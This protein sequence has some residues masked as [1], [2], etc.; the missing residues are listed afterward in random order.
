MIDKLV[1]RDIFYR[2]GLTNTTPFTYRDGVTYLDILEEIKWKILNEIKPSIENMDEEVR[3]KFAI[4]QANFEE[5]DKQWTQ[6]LNS[7]DPTAVRAYVEG[8]GIPGIRDDFNAFRTSLN[9][10][11]DDRFNNINGSLQSVNQLIEALNTLTATHTSQIATHTSQIDSINSNFNNHHTRHEFGG[12]DELTINIK[13]VKDLTRSN[14]LNRLSSGYF[15]CVFL[16][17]SHTNDG[18]LEGPNGWGG[19]FGY[20]YRVGNL[21]AQTV[22]ECQEGINVSNPTGWGNYV[23]EAATGGMTSGTYCPSGTVSNIGVLKPD[24][25]FHMIGTNDYANLISPSTYKTNVRKAINDI[26]NVSSNTIQILIVP[27]PRASVASTNSWEDY[28]NAMDE[29]ANEYYSNDKFYYFEY[30]KKFLR[31][32]YKN[33]INSWG[34]LDDNIHGN[35]MLHRELAEE[36]C[37]FLGL[38]S[39]AVTFASAFYPFDLNRQGEVVASINNLIINKVPVPRIVRVEASIVG[40]ATSEGDFK[41][42]IN[43]NTSLFHFVADSRVQSISHQHTAIVPANVD[44]KVSFNSGGFSVSGN[45]GDYYKGSIECRYI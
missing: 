37:E 7:L 26:W 38:P 43:N 12:N 24:V 4:V 35:R 22:G 23:W 14:I 34:L 45:L 21:L 16:G 28:V 42:D 17:D 31:N 20:S 15:K 30:G 33:A 36:I 11:V 9:S 8:L 10:S 25:V 29:L 44:T 32:N 39:P 40:V 13:Q 27:W 41:I 1:F 2:N 18:S 19:E 5:L 3:D 6:Q